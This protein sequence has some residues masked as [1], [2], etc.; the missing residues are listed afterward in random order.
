MFF[1][2]KYFGDYWFRTGTPTFLIELLK[3]RNRISPVLKPVEVGEKVLEGYDPATLNE[4]PL[5]FQTGYLTVKSIRTDSNNSKRIFTLDIPNSEVRDAFMED[6]LSAYTAC[7]SDQ[8]QLLIPKMQKQIY[9]GDTKGLEKNLRMLLANI[10]TSPPALSTREGAIEDGAY[11]HS[12][13]S[14]WMNMLGFEPQ[15]EVET[16]IGRIDTVLHHADLTIVAEIKYSSKRGADRL[17]KEAMKQIHNRKY[18]EKYA[19]RKVILMGV[20]FAGKEVK[21]KLEELKN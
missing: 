4:I 7:R 13:F 14:V 11:Y 20:A 9:N 10:P 16:N 19:D 6:L 12:M 17:L 1:G 15:N 18:Y 21:C 2:K 3:K 8:V 5:L